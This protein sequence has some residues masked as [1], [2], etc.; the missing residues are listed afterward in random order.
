MTVHAMPAG[1]E[2]LCKGCGRRWP[3][4]AQGIPLAGLTTVRCRGCQ[5]IIAWA[6]SGTAR[7]EMSAALREKSCHNCGRSI[8]RN[9]SDVEFKNTFAPRLDN[10]TLSVHGV[11]EGLKWGFVRFSDLPEKVREA[12]RAQMGSKGSKRSPA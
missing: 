8:D 3:S 10:R 7:E 2:D 1:G 5:D 12:V 11:I 6:H 9:V 4:C